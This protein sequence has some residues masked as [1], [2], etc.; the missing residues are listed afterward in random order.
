MKYIL[1]MPVFL[2]LV[3]GNVFAQETEKKIPEFNFFRLDK[4]VFTNK[5]LAKDKLLF[6]VFFDAGCGHCQHAV[7][8]IDEHRN[9]FDKAAMYLITLDSKE[10][11]KVF[12]NKYGSHLRN[13]RNV[14]I[15]LETKQEF[16]SKFNPRKY[17]SMFLYSQKK[18]L[19]LYDDNEQNLFMFLKQMKKSGG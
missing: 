17:P 10:K 14:T 16:I 13:K 15:L 9:E 1:L 19:L 3:F 2:F 5:N 12:M 4:T 8:Y 11:V 6:F 18:E 7:K